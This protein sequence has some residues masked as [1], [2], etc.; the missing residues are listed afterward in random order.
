[1]AEDAIAIML[2]SNEDLRGKGSDPASQRVPPGQVAAHMQAVRDGLEVSGTLW[3][4]LLDLEG[5]QT[6]LRDR[7]FCADMSTHRY[8]WV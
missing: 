2:E 4:P 3:N 5:L 7:F 1:M 8:H 6:I